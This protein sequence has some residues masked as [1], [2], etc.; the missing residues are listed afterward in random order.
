[1]EHAEKEISV[2]YYYYYYYSYYYFFKRN[3]N[4]YLFCSFKTVLLVIPWIKP[5]ISHVRIWYLFGR[6]LSQRGAQELLV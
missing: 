5:Y 6:I 4:P 2:A 1:M 3:K